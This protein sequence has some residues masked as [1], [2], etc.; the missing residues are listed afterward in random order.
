MTG[1]SKRAG[2]AV[3]LLLWGLLI[4]GTGQA[5]NADSQPVKDAGDGAGQS[6][7]EALRVELGTVSTALSEAANR[8]IALRE[9]LKEQAAQSTSY[10]ESLT[11]EDSRALL[12]K[13]KT[14]SAEL[15]ALRL[16]LKTRMEASGSFKARENVLRDL[17]RQLLE[18]RSE[19]RRLQQERSRLAVELKA[20][21]DAEKA[22]QVAPEAM[23]EPAPT[24]GGGER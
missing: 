5:G 24:T 4:S 14:L 20:A 21:E 10:E 22:D 13:I 9:Q 8:E 1:I 6:G 19:M 7:M 15:D 12:A 3:I 11:D 2:G 18:T 17:H 23:T 16:E